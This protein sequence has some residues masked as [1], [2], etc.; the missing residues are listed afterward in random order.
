MNQHLGSFS[1]SIIHSDRLRC[2]HNSPAQ[3]H[4]SLTGWRGRGKKITH[5]YLLTNLSLSGSGDIIYHGKQLASNNP[6]WES[7]RWQRK[8]CLIGRW[9]KKCSN[10]LEGLLFYRRLPKPI[11]S[12]S[13][14]L[15]ACLH[16]TR[17]E[18]QRF[19]KPRRPQYA[20]SRGGQEKW[21]GRTRGSF[22]LMRDDSGDGAGCSQSWS[23]QPAVRDTSPGAVNDCLCR[24]GAMQKKKKKLLASAIM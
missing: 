14:W 17:V 16:G 1:I 10:N 18:M 15:L 21:R 7:V 9:E 22:L 2:L 3:L 11:S 4:E 20:A 8:M 12:L 5:V 13:I 24:T 19:G 23:A 6:Q